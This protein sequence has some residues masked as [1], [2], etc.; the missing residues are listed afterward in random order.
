MLRIHSKNVFSH[1]RGTNC[2]RPRSTASIAGLA[3][4]AALQNHWS[5]SHGSMISPER[6]WCGTISTWSSTFSISPS[7]SRSAS[8]CFLAAKRSSPRYFSGTASFSCASRSKMLIASRP[9]RR[10]T[11]K[12][13]KSCAGVILTAPLPFS[14][15]AYSSATI[16]IS[17][18]T[19][20]SRTV[21]PIRS[22]CRRSSGCTATP[23]SPSIVS[24]RVVAT[25]IK[26]PESPSTG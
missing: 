5:V 19:S 8:T 18:P 24:G 23:V 15:S 20:G 6:S 10:P 4:S 3:S 26:R 7:A 25:T 14:G 17:R 12:S 22:A 16:G 1:C 13:L 11:S 2:V 21:L 9:C